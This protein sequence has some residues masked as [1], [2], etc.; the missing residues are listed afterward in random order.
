METGMLHLH[1]V[2]RWIILILLLVT[3]YQAFSK[4]ESL[5]SGSLWLLIFT[6]TMFVIGLYQLIAGR[7]G[8]TKGLPDGIE[9]MKNTFYRFYWIEHPLMMI[10]A[11][12]LITVARRKAKALNYKAT[13]WLLLIALIVILA[14]VPWPFRQ[15]VGRPWFPGM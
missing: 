4:K 15:I 6:H 13:G 10:A 2:L 12:A 11:V 1:N 14:A 8:I 9:L 5:R 7:Y 3:L